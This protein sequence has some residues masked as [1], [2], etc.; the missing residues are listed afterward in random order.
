MILEI[1]GDVWVQQQIGILLVMNEKITMKTIN[2][3]ARDPNF[4]SWFSEKYQIISC[5]CP[6]WYADQRKIRK[7]GKTPTRGIGACHHYGQLKTDEL[8][9]LPI[10][11]LAAERCHLYLWATCPL[12]PDALRVMEAWGFKFCTVAHVWIKMNKGA[13]EKAQQYTKII[14]LITPTKSA[15][16]AFLN[17]LAWYGPGYY[18]GSNIELVLLGRKGKPFKHAQGRKSSQIIFAPHGE[19]HSQKPEEMQDRIEW[20]YPEVGPRLELFGRRARKLWTVFGDEV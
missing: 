11:D 19:K 15:V 3:D 14:Q 18:A 6:W 2:G 12:L 1:T 10:E 5:D 8:C 20:M 4:L 16:G 7:D 13:W 9:K 17:G